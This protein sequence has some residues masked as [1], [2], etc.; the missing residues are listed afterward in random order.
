[1]QGDLLLT[2][3]LLVGLEE[4]LDLL[5]DLSVWEFDVVLDGAIIGHEGQE[6][7]IGDIE[8]CDI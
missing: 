4:F 3:I 8:L 6:A 2:G 7:I 5:T 1:M